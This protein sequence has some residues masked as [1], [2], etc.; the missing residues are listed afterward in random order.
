MP[1][2]QVKGSTAPMWW[3]IL[4]VIAVATAALINYDSERED[5]RLSLF[6]ETTASD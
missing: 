5:S 6:A 2:S 1:D 4:F 3:G